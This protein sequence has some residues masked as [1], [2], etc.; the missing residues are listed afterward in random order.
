MN[1]KQKNIFAN[2]IISVCIAVTTYITVVT[3]ESYRTLGM[4]VPSDVVIALLTFWGGELLVIA[5]RQI[6]GTDI[7]KK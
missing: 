7:I 2:V 1:K 4:P 5:L 6:F 3:I